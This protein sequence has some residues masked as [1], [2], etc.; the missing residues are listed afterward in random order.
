M[1]PLVPVLLT[2]LK[3]VALIYLLLL[4][5]MYF[6]QRSLLFYATPPMSFA[7]KQQI[8]FQHHDQT[9]SGWQLNPGKSKALLYFGGNAE[10]VGYQIKPFSERYPDHTIY[11]IEYR[12]YGRSS[13]SPSEQALFADALFVF[14]QIQSKH[15]EFHAVG[16]SLGSGV[17]TYLAAHRP[18]DKLVLITPYDS[19]TNVAAGHYP[20]L[21]VAWLIK[22]KFESWRYAQTLDIPVLIAIAGQDRVVPPAR[23][24]AL[25][26]AFSRTLPASFT[27]EQANHNNLDQFDD[28]QKRVSLFLQSALS[29]PANSD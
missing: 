28:Y 21:P 18:I 25:A 2:L 12:G 5:F 4:A 3:S 26:E 17:A 9:L 20:F 24:K 23:A 8:T 16:R 7:P 1:K 15:N 13:G 29:K 11:L 27:V 6:G 14:D 22:D 10:P 19:M